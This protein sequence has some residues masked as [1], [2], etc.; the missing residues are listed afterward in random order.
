[1]SI[2]NDRAT[3][4]LRWR[5]KMEEIELLNKRP[6][7]LKNRNYYLFTITFANGKEFTNALKNVLKQKPNIP[8]K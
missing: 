5:N 4:C 6:Q 8:Y 2:I 1:L 3:E 7:S